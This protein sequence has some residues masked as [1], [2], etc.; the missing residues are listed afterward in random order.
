VLL[1]ANASV[2]IAAA[3]AQQAKHTYSGNANGGA[4]AELLHFSNDSKPMQQ[5]PMLAYVVQLPILMRCRLCG[6]CE[7]VRV[8][9]HR[10][11]RLC[12]MMWKLLWASGTT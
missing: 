9:P 7:F 12:G 1:L 8:Y 6:A 5:Q 4:F 11:L 3:C 10:L 2:D